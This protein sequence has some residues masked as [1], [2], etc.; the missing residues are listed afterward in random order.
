MGIANI[1]NSSDNSSSNAR[2]NSN[3][4]NR[5]IYK[6]EER[7]KYW[8]ERAKEDPYNS[9]EILKFVQYMQENGKAML[10][11]KAC[12]V[13]LLEISRIL[14]KEFS[15]ATKEDIKRVIEEI[16]SRDYSM[17][18]VMK[19]RQVIKYF[20]K[21]VYGNNEYYPEV[22]RWIHKVSK[23]KKREHSSLSYDDFLT[24]EEVQRLIDTADTIQKKAF[25]A[26]GYETGSRPEELL[27]IRLKDILFDRLGA[28]II[29]RGKTGER[30]TRVVVYVSLLKEWLNIHPYRNDREAYLWLS[31]ATN[32]R[33][34]PIG[35]RSAEKMFANIMKL[36]GI[37]KSTRLY[38]LRHT[39]ST[40]LANRM[41]EAQ[42]CSY[43]GWRLGTKV[44]QRYIHLAGINID[45]TLAS[46]AGLEDHK[47]ESTLKVTRCRRCKEVLSP[48]N[49]F[50]IKCGLDVNEDYISN[51]ELEKEVKELKEI[52]YEILRRL[53]LS[54]TSISS[55][56]SGSIS[57]SSISSSTS[58]RSG[59]SKR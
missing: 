46:I 40:H 4:S 3:S 32:H 8:I 14:G 43:F 26:V 20:Y 50:C 33:W 15:S 29:V 44:V 35:L 27:N 54:S 6:R 23:D 9:I 36:A 55:N 49:K 1:G 5:D 53:D 48:N 31:E 45:N 38:I 21:V 47:E 39:R 13:I 28:K 51:N 59:G 24:E 17:H 10:W 56:S 41:T 7:L 22:V 12:I 57:I 19:F 58:S 16:D 37:K 30:V 42:L 11:I 52:V 2:S 25:I 18:T 34:K